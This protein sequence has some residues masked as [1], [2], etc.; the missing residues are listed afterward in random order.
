MNVALGSRSDRIPDEG[1]M[2]SVRRNGSGASPDHEGRAPVVA[3]LESKHKQKNK[4]EGNQSLQ[5]VA[6]TLAAKGDRARYCRIRLSG[7]EKIEAGMAVRFF[8][9]LVCLDRSAKISKA[10]ARLFYICRLSPAFAHKGESGASQDGSS[11]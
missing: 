1:T 2:K 8:A 4:S 9:C 7:A 5:V 11:G 10:K 6:S 3:R